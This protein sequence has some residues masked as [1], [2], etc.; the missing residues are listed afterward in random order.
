MVVP[1]GQVRGPWQFYGP[2][3]NMDITHPAYLFYAERVIHQIVSHFKDHPAVIGYQIDNETSAYGTAGPSVQ[4][5]FVEYLKKQFGSVSRLNELWGFVYWGQ[6]VND[7]DE[8]PPRDG[9][10]NPGYKLEWE[11]YQRKLATDFLAWQARIVGEYKRPEQFITHDFHGGLHLDVDAP[12]IARVLDVVGVNPYHEVQDRLDGWWPAFVGDYARSL[13]RKNY[14]VTETNAQTKGWDSKGQ[15]PPYDGQLRL[16]VYG[17]VASGANL[18]EYWHWHSL[19]YGQETY[20]K[21]VLGHDLAPNRVYGE[22]AR[23]ASELKDVGPRLVNLKKEAKVAILHSIDSHQGIRFM[24]FHDTVNYAAVESQMHQALY[25]LNVDVDFVFPETADLSAYRVLVV[26]P[27]Y[28]ASDETLEKI[29][30]Y[31]RGGGHAVVAFKSGFCNEYSTVRSTRQPGLLREAVGASYQEFSTLREPVALKGDPF[32]AGAEN[33]VSVWAEMLESE[34]AQVL[35]SY[36]HPFFGRWAAITRNTFGKGTLTYVG[37]HL[38]DAL[39]EKLLLN[40]LRLAELAGPEQALPR[41][42]RLRQGTTPSGDHLRFFF[43][44]SAQPVKVAYPFGA[45]EDWLTKRPVKRGALTLEPWGVA[46]IAER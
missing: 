35:A 31:V 12:G 3:Q 16:S 1:L 21:G 7:W 18:V 24:P 10:L 29:K 4:V 28:V 33:K 17:H 43:N 41:S 14:L 30:A 20:W 15:F 2:R 9:A 5:G 40:V 26:P 11:R 22:L 42:V 25:R 45:A 8:F 37:T 36:D 6:L 13:K 44:Y 46:I 27:L 32:G 38:S 19:H 34:G 23:V 39:M